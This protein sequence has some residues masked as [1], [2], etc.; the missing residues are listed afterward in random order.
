MSSVQPR[1]VGGETVGFYAVLGKDKTTGK[2]PRKYFKTE[3]EAE[4]YILSKESSEI[5][6]GV[7]MR[8]STQ[9]IACI[10]RLAEK[11]AT[12]NEAT[13]YFL[14]FGVNRKPTPVGEVIDELIAQKEQVG[15]SP[16][17]IDDLKI[18]LGTFREY[19][20]DDTIIG[21]ITSDQ[22]QSYIYVAQNGLSGLSKANHIRILKLLF[23]FAIGKGYT[24][25]NPVKKIDKPTF[26]FAA[27]K[28][29]S[30]E[31]F[32]VLLNHCYKNKW[33]DRLAIFVLEGFCGIRVEEATRMQWKDIDL[34][35]KV[36]KLDAD[37]AKGPRWRHNIIPENAMK[38]FLAFEDKRLSARPI[39]GENWKTL[40]R[41][42]IHSAK[43]N[44][45]KNC[46]R[47]SFASFAL[48]AGWKPEDV[49]NYMGH[50]GSLKT[51]NK[52][53][54]NVTPNLETSQK[55]WAIVPNPE[56]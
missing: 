48:K 9:I 55:W 13:E 4:A 37:N 7:L 32:T 31:D 47:H 27:P 52:S 11:G 41:S 49:S 39:I 26:K 17:H 51:L 10:Q 34:T 36:V 45:P 12:F 1:K 3:K 38:W 46:I 29:M 50:G 53:Y 6:M 19:I 20:K 56:T 40:I 16:N 15:R 28:V 5:D 54:R 30:P 18:K 8:D 14:K 2:V 35:E 43:V 23:N 33:Y 21:D 42:A 24:S 22:I 25:V 44:H